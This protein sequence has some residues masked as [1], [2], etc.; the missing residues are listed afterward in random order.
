MACKLPFGAAG[1]LRCIFDA[2]LL[3]QRCEP[4]FVGDCNGFRV[5][6]DPETIR[7]P[8]NA[9]RQPL[10]SQRRYVCKIKGAH[11]STSCIRTTRRKIRRATA[12]VCCYLD[13]RAR[14]ATYVNIRGVISLGAPSAAFSPA[15]Q[16]WKKLS[17]VQVGP[18]RSLKPPAPV[19]SQSK[20]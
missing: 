4:A 1:H 7:F 18:A 13:R 11:I 2:P 19:S 20:K 14:W 15:R 8:F 6:A 17:F 10:S 9:H 3:E 12:G 16:S 5:T